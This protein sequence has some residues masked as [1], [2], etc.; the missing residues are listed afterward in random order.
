MAGAFFVAAFLTIFANVGFVRGS[1]EAFYEHPVLCEA[2]K[3]VIPS[4]APRYRYFPYFIEVYRCSGGCVTD[5][6]TIHCAAT[7]WN[8]ITG[9]VVDPLLPTGLREIS[10]VNHTSCRCA[11][12]KKAEDC[13]EFEDYVE[14][15]C[16]CQCK[17]P[18]QPPT[19]CPERFSWNPSQCN[20]VAKE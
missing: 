2:R 16:G 7:N 12:I 19:P 3:V 10:L 13:S 1:V 14:G 5:P 9:N 6:K 4:D 18:N 20:C 11:C 15:I 17:Y 8:N